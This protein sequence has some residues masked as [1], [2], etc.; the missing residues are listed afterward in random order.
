MKRKKGGVNI[1]NTN[2][3]SSVLRLSASVNGGSK[4]A[5]DLTICQQSSHRTHDVLD[6]MLHFRNVQPWTS[7]NIWA[8]GQQV[9]PDWHFNPSTAVLSSEGTFFVVYLNSADV[10]GGGNCRDRGFQ[11][12][13]HA[14]LFLEAEMAV[15]VGANILGGGAVEE[16]A[17]DRTRTVAFRRLTLMLFRHR[18]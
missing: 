17:D 9:V 2:K 4:I 8:H 7:G 16:A 14:S 1:Q 11:G 10:R 3:G 6:L 15:A 12:G 5:C 13:F 18:S